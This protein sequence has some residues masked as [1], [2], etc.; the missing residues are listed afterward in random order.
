MRSMALKTVGFDR[1]LAVDR[2]TQR[3]DHAADHGF[4]HRNRHDAAGA[5]DLVAFLDARVFAEQHGADLVFFQVQRDAG[6][7]AL[8]LDQF[9]GHDVFKAVDAGDT[10]A[11][12][13]HR[14]GFGYVDCAFVVL[15]LLAQHARDFIRPNLSHKE[16]LYMCRQETTPVPA[17]SV[18]CP[19]ARARSR[20]RRWNQCAPP[21]RP[22]APG[23]LKT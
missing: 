12:R 22:P 4:A 7:A 11:H 8:E 23:R 5:A 16:T 13:N 15:N 18:I 10:V 19:I 20:R 9:A 6:N 2:L 17:W 14:A 21:P 3:V 1:A